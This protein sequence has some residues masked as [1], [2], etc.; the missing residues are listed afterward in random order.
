MRD[1]PKTTEDERELIKQAGHR[2][3]VGGQ[4]GKIGRLQFDFLVSQGLEPDHV[5]LD[6]GCGALRGGRHF[7]KYLDPGNYLGIDLH[8]ELLDAGA[9]KEVGE[10][11]MEE[12][13]PELI[14]SSDFEFER[15]AKRPDFALAQSL[16]THLN[17]DDIS[18]CLRKLSAVAN[19]GCVFWTTFRTGDSSNNPEQSGSKLP[20][21][22]SPEELASYGAES[23]WDTHFHGEWG[24]P[25]GQVMMRFTAPGDR[26]GSAG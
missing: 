1:R 26:P 16:F 14:A 13:R 6:V 23:G 7:I 20:F 3:F 18:H 21:R 17:P 5:F 15:F 25:R 4:W 19:P 10:E 24:H 22:Y 12:K 2:N 8:Q 11:M 9:E